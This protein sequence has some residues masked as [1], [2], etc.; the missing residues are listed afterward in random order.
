[1]DETLIVLPSSRAIREELLQSKSKNL[2]LPKYITMSEFVSKLCV[3]ENF[4]SLDDDTRVLLLLEASDFNSFKD[5]KIERNFFTFTKNSTYIFKFFEELSAELYDISNLEKSDIYGKYEEHI[6]ILKELYKRYEDLCTSKKIIDKI[7][8]PKLYKFNKTYIKTYKKTILKVDGYLT[9]FE[10]SLLNQCCKYSEVIIEFSTTKFNKKMQNK[11]L[12]FGIE[13][14][15]DFLYKI[16]F[17]SKKILSKTKIT[18]NTNVT[19]KAFSE[20]LLQVAYIKQKIYEGLQKGYKAEK[21]AVIL[22]DEKIADTLRVFDDKTNF[23]FAMG[24]TFTKTKIYEKLNSTCQMLDQAS[25][26]NISRMKRFGDDT[27]LKLVLHYHKKN[28]DFN[29]VE[30]LENYKKDFD[31]KDELKIFDEELYG[32]SKIIP[33]MN[34]MSIKSTLSLFLQRLSKRSIDNVGGGKITVMGLLETRLINFDLV[35]IVDFSDENVP[36]RNDKDMFLNTDIRSLAN[37]PTA[38]DRQNLQKHYY[39]LLLLRSKEVAISYVDSAQ[40]SGSVFL[41]QLG[42]NEQNGFEQSQYASILF[43]SS[44]NTQEKEDDIILPYSFKDTTLSNTK[45]KTFLECKRKYYFKYIKSIN[46]FEIPK[47][48]PKEYEIGNK[49]HKALLNL[50]TKK[51]SYDNVENLQ[52][53]LYRE[54]DLICKNN[55]VEKYLMEIQKKRLEKFCQNEIKRFNEGWHVDMCEKKFECNFAGVRIG[56]FI[57]RIDKKENQLHILDYKTGSYKLYN[58]NN[59]SNA[60]DFQLEFYYLLSANYGDIVACGFYDLKDGTIIQE[61]FLEEKLKILESNIKEI[62]N[63]KEINFAKCED[64]KNCIYCDYATMCQRN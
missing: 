37:L 54:L 17:N 47:D 7:F 51:S 26:E 6:L 63:L 36:K 24:K 15:N 57:D 59:F 5:L 9:N 21:T 20:P 29:I 35:I 25:T 53:D 45:L 48:M 34:S 1:M 38:K 22:P 11:F 28:K 19:A 61:P 43:K 42:I 16:S 50:Y 44:K 39:D 41:K 8:L 62:T 4:K 27:Y 2:F 3:V 31:D 18:K 60:T 12:E 49:V 56:G 23:N 32:F 55:E 46:G 58:K 40:S 33:N 30:F 14:Q 64:T 52:K 13:L 10:F